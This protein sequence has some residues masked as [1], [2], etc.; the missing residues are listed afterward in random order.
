MKRLSFVVLAL[1]LAASVMV[2]QLRR[3]AMGVTGGVGSS[4]TLGIGYALSENLQIG[5]GLTFTSTSTTTTFAAGDNKSSQTLFGVDVMAKYYLATADNL[6]TFLGGTV[7]FGSMTTESTPA[8]GSTTS[9]SGSAF[10]VGALY[11]AEYWFSPRF[12]WSG[13]VGAG[14]T[15]SSSDG[16]PKVSSTDLGTMYATGLTWWFN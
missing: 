14:F 15:S 7:G 3:S 1:V 11:G 13:Y 9:V 4:N 16:P 6:S 12:S 5:A 2:G 10:S 8:G